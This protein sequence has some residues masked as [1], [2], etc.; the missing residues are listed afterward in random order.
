MSPPSAPAPRPVALVPRP[1]AP[2]TYAEWCKR[3]EGEAFTREELADVHDYFDALEA[4]RDRERL[5][6]REPPE[7]WLRMLKDGYPWGGHPLDPGA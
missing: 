3:H 6:Y 1:S 4:E 5:R 7:W 2:T